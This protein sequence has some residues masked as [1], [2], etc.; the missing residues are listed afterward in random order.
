MGLGL[1][2]LV[3]KKLLP[4]S[5]GVRTQALDSRHRGP[6]FPHRLD[7]GNDHNMQSTRMYTMVE[8]GHRTDSSLSA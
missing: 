1:F 7:S 5:F 6:L 3:Q 4:M 8:T 2:Y